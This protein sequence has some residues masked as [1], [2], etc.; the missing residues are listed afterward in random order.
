MLHLALRGRHLEM[1][2]ASDT[3]SPLP[4]WGCVIDA[5]ADRECGT[6]GRP[7]LRAMRLWRC[8]SRSR[9]LRHWILLAGL[10]TSG[11]GLGAPHERP[12]D[13][14]QCARKCRRPGGTPPAPLVK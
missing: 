4:S 13:T 8:R 5:G 2:D 12:I 14:H 7:A 1:L 10:G 3:A 6:Q 9:R 11:R